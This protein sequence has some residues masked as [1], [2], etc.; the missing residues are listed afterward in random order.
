MC[1]KWSAACWN[2]TQCVWVT[3][4]AYIYHPDEIAIHGHRNKYTCADRFLQHGPLTRYV[5]LWVAH[6]PGMPVTFFHHSLQ[7]QP[8]VS[9]PDMHHGTCVTH[10]PW[11]MSGSLTRGGEENAPDI[12][13]AC[14]THNFTYLARGPWQWH[15]NPTTHF[16][17]ISSPISPFPSIFPKDNSSFKGL[18]Q[19]FEN[20]LATIL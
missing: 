6:A 8:P 7:R 10:V 15:I 9:D 17:P 4:I 5:K 11:C 19:R 2:A 16:H 18:N 20:K 1:P 14:A 12:P 3:Y 13:G